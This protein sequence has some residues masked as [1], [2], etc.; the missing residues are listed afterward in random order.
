MDMEVEDGL[1]AR[2]PVRLDQVQTFRGESLVDQPR[3]VLCHHHGGGCVA[4]GDAQMSDV[5]IRGTTS[6]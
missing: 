2:G 6:V 1:P 5:W 3:D 4:L